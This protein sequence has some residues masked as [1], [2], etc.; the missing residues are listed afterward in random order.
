M[1]SID[2]R[3]DVSPVGIEFVLRPA[4]AQAGPDELVFDVIGRPGGFIT[5]PLTSRHVHTT[6]SERYD[7]LAGAMRVQLDGRMH[8]LRAGDH[9]TVPAG[10]PH[11]QLP[12]GSEP[13]HVRVT[14]KP[15]GRTEEYLRYL[16]QL[17][18]DGQFNRLGLPRPLAGARM[19]HEF[20][21]VG[22]AT[23]APLALQ[24]AAASA[25]LRVWREYA[26]V[27]EW[28]AAAPPE[29]VYDVLV[30]G[31][32]YPRWWR[33]VY[34]DVATDG[35]PV[36]GSVL[37]QHFKG[38]L[39]YHLHTRSKLTRLIPG[40]LIEADVDGDLRG[41]G[42]WTL[43]SIPGGTHIRFDWTV[44]ADRP[45]LRILTPLLRPALRANHNWAIARAIDGLEPYVQ[46]T[47]NTG[48]DSMSG[49][50][51]ALVRRFF[52]EFCNGRRSEL[53]EEIIAPDYV[54]HGPQAPPAEGPEE[55]IAR[56]GLYQEAVDGH[57]DV[58]QMI[59]TGDY[60]IARWIGSGTH[61]GE[62]M[63]IDPTGKPISVD[64]IS[65]FRITDG[66]IAEEWTVWD[67]L[68]LLQQVGAVPAAA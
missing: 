39:P 68:G 1:P 37:S 59:S 36:V 11:R 7:V 30:D 16:A 33:P 26:F 61:R 53:A 15:A 23:L 38:R 58:Q 44:Y 17:A 50:N 3:L 65:I 63:G 66:K 27:D 56:V 54:S 43:T 52:E 10:K 32:T 47:T 24:R 6:Q 60:V 35:P 8:L 9:L 5:N 42:I 22:Y 57:W 46:S 28:D 20:A 12:A 13:G 21:D 25:L 55:V 14:V 45:L 49:A 4:G 41:R 64:A 18:R 67:A 40:K 31:R 62:L 34:I 19:L 51:E 2:E 48:G 29:A